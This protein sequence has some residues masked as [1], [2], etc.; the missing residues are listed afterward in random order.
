MKTVEL[1]NIKDIVGE[2]NAVIDNDT[3]VKIEKGEYHI[4]PENTLL[5]TFKITNSMPEQKATKYGGVYEKNIGITI[6]GKKNVVIDGGGSKLITHCKLIPFCAFESE[7]V[8]F[9]NFSFD[10]ATPTQAE[11]ECLEVGDG[12][13]VFKVHPDVKYRIDDEGKITWYGDNFEFYPVDHYCQRYL[14]EKETIVSQWEGPMKD[15]TARYEDLGNNVIKINTTS[16][17]PQFE[18]ILYPHENPY[19]VEVGEHLQLRD[20]IRDRSGAF[21][22][23]CKN[24]TFESMNMHY[25]HGLG[26]VAQRTDGLAMKSV[27]C[28]PDP[29]TGRI[30]S[31]FADGCQ[32]SS[33]RGQVTVT[34]CHFSGSNDDAINIHGTYMKIVKSEDNTVT[35]RYIQPDTYN[36]NIFEDGDI[37]EVCDPEYMLRED[38]ATVVSSRLINPYD[39]EIILDKSA[40]KFKEG[41]VVENVSASP[42]VHIC[43]C[44]VRRCPT[45]GFLVSTRGKVLIENNEFYD[46]HR[47]AVLVANDAMMWYET[48]PVCDITVRNNRIFNQIE[49]PIFRIQPENKK[50]KDGEFVHNNITFEN[51]IAVGSERV[52]WIYAKSTD[53]LILRSN[54]ANF[55]PLDSEFDHCGKVIVEE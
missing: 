3:T 8:T 7:N 9:K 39:I 50:Y 4:Y 42:D 17:L 6:D 53:N 5:R 24:V 15:E 14:P 20:G 48:G 21:F 33:C 19:S 10:Y 35:A 47:A 37:I 45:R 27:I 11:L 49:K 38:R 16:G 12:Y 29:K 44:T 18:W 32:I 34:D 55:E 51:N 52:A 46:L 13:Y 22:D 23:R 28:A 54:T 40:E 25:M 1:K 41:F 43:D 26:I 36:Y 2:V 31:C 30:I